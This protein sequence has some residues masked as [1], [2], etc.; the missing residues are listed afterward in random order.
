MFDEEPDRD[1]AEN[2]VRRLDEADMDFR[3]WSQIEASYRSAAGK[4][5]YAERQQ[6]FS[7]KQVHRDEAWLG[8]RS[9][10]LNDILGKVYRDAAKARALWDELE[11]KFGIR[12]AERMIEKDPFI[13]G[14]V[15]GIRMGDTRTSD[16][17]EAKR[18]GS[19]IETDRPGIPGK[20]RQGHAS[21]P[22]LRASA[23]QRAL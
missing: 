20:R 2:A 21:A 17:R 23:H 10:S 5:R 1:P 14:A 22:I 15:R 9:Q 18:I 12:D 6:S 13:L 8:K 19:G 16:R 3:Y 11:Q 4:V 7:E